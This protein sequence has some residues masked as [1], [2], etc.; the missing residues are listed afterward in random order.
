MSVSEQGV[1]AGHPT[2]YM[3]VPRTLVFVQ[4][5][6]KTLLLRGAANKRLWAGKLNG[7]GG[8]VEAGE[9][10]LE[11]AQRELKEETGL[12]QVRL[13][14]A[15]VITVDTGSSPG[16]GIFVFSGEAGPGE[17]LP[18]GEGELVWLDRGELEGQPVV[19]DLPALLERLE[20]Q[21]P[22]DPPFSG[23]SGYDLEGQL[24]IEFAG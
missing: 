23:R 20:R 4:R 16:V 3:L 17:V 11:A 1:G 2:R 5:D 22:G 7:I 18:G 12:D 13:R 14:L 9:D 15:G 19:A 6:G 21:K 8:H 10:V 24:H